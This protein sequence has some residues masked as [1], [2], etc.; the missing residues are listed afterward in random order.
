MEVIKLKRS[1]IKEE[2]LE[3]TKDDDG[4]YSLPTAVI[5]SQFIYWSERVRDFQDFIEQENKRRMGDEIVI[6]HGWFYKTAEELAEET[7][8]RLSKS[9]MLR[10]IKKLIELGFVFE[11]ENPY[12]KWDR[13]RQYRVDLNKINE[14]LIENGYNGLEGY[15][16]I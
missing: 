6:S 4:K 5:L 3:I 2:L 9:N 7:L 15:R 12:H 11:R 13:T 16:Q 8:L 10:H 1:V 14:T